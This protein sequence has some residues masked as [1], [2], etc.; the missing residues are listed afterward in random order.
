LTSEFVRRR[1]AYYGQHPA[2]PEPA[3]KTLVRSI[4]SEL[5]GT[6]VQ[7]EEDQL[8]VAFEADLEPSQASPHI[9]ALGDVAL[10]LFNS[11]EFAYVY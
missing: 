11:N 9:R 6:P 2:A 8:P 5:T 7:V 4:T 3:P 10:A 1:E